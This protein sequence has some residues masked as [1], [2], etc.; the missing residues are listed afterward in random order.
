MRKL[1]GGSS[2]VRA[3]QEGN[4]QGKP[5]LCYSAN[6]LM[7]NHNP[8][9]GE[10][11]GRNDR[12]RGL[13][14]ASQRDLVQEPLEPFAGE[15]G[16]LVEPFARVDIVMLDRQHHELLRFASPRIE[17]LVAFDRADIVVARTD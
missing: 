15:P 11:L 3:R 10:P 1:A 5:K 12:A 16:R 4:G 13:I 8:T 14:H 6:A 17:F 2:G 9:S 7:E